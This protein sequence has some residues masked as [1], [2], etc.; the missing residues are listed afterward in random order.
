MKKF[1][2][3]LFLLLMTV[4]VHAGNINRLIF[5]GDSLSDDGNLYKI[6]L[7]LIP[8]SPPYYKGRFTN[9]ETWAEYV[10]K[11]YRHYKIYALGG[12]TAVSLKPLDSSIPTL[13]LELE[14]YRYLGESLFKNR[15]NSLF[16]IWI[17]GND[18]LFNPNADVDSAT[19]KVIDQISW[20]IKT[21]R[22]NGGKNF[23]ILNL[24][25]L[26][27]IP[28]IR[29]SQSENQLHALTI[30]HNQKLDAMI[31]DLQNSYSDIHITFFNIH[32]NISDFLTN[33]EKYNTKYNT[34]VTQLTEACWKGEVWLRPDKSQPRAITGMTSLSP[35]LME[36]FAVNESYMKGN[37]PCAN[38]DDYF[39]WDGVHPSAIAHNILG[40]MIIEELATVF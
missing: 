32:N 7:H 12:A 21:L 8:K 11:H 5:F 10:G 33:P 3:V 16:T 30:L 25:D 15:S 29:G 2:V 34:H 1:I 13:N 22:K 19:T 35:S 40:Q 6:T 14:V 4:N 27:L 24:P 36:T 23:L 9:G 26:S 37:I 20:A 18:Y 38:P 17:G 31:Q 39:F 28:R